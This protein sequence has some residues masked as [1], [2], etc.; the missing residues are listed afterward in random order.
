MKLLGKL[1]ITF[2]KR[3]ILVLKK[4]IM[5]NTSSKKQWVEPKIANLDIEETLSGPYSTGAENGYQH[6]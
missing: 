1:N 6:S 4:Y 3:I 2:K 5:S